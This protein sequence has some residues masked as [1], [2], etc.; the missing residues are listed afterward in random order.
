[1]RTTPRRGVPGE[2]SGATSYLKASSDTPAGIR[3]ATARF[4]DLDDRL[5]VL[6]EAAIEAGWVTETLSNLDRVWDLLT[7]E[8]RQRFLH[9]VISRIE[10]FG[11]DAPLVVHL[12]TRV[13]DRLLGDGQAPAISAPELGALP[14]EVAGAS[15]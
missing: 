10:A 4:A 2:A 13:L 8:N 12:D 11:P 6:E 9:A 5:N 1:M 15:A 14:E 3:P 7:A